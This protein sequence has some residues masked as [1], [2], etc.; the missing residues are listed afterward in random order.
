MCCGGWGGWGVGA[1]WGGRGRG[2]PCVSALP[3][4]EGGKPGRYDGWH[5]NMT[6]AQCAFSRASGLPPHGPA[7]QSDEGKAIIAR[8]VRCSLCDGSGLLQEPVGDTWAWCPHCGGNRS[9]IDGRFDPEGLGAHNDP[10]NGAEGPV[11]AV[12]DFRFPR[13]LWAERNAH[14]ELVEER[15]DGSQLRA[16]DVHRRDPFLRWVLSLKGDARLVR[17][18]EMKAAFREMVGEVIELYGGEQEGESSG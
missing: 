15:E 9:A 8:L 10:M 17:P 2:D 1:S 3:S 5:M 12:V 4:D 13:S 16:F 6:E 18:P 7:R 11:S 14:G